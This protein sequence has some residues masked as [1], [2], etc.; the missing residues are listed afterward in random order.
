MIWLCLAAS[1]PKIT[2][3]HGYCLLK[4]KP[5]FSPYSLH[6]HSN[7]S[8]VFCWKLS[9]PKK[10]AC[11]QRLEGV[12]PIHPG[13]TLDAFCWALVT[14]LCALLSR[15]TLENQAQ[16][17]CFIVSERG[18]RYF[19]DKYIKSFRFSWTD[20]LTL[21]ASMLESGSQSKV[22]ILVES[23]IPATEIMRPSTVVSTSG[24]DSSFC[25]GHRHPFKCSYSSFLYCDVKFT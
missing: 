10:H 6:K 22:T 14:S 2:L 15:K 12:T 13:G 24:V 25:S 18:T 17:W 9:P 21:C 19:R 16:L 4:R 3:S 7:H 1:C 23:N 5:S 20:Q 11:T 8:Q